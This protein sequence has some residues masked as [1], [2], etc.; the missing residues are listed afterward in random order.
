M[1]N[2]GPVFQL[3][4]NILWTTIDR[5]KPRNSLSELDQCLRN[6]VLIFQNERFGKIMW[7]QYNYTQIKEFNK[8][9]VHAEKG[10]LDKLSRETHNS[11]KWL[12]YLPIPYNDIIKITHR[13]DT[14]IV[15][16]W[17]SY[18]LSLW[19]LISLCP[20]LCALEGPAVDGETQNT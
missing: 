2:I 6:L 5:G 19:M 17:T 9:A 14:K 13:S 15:S 4:A 7:S 10:E 3:D 16:F 11:L 18:S 20:Y 8:N 12:D 1:N